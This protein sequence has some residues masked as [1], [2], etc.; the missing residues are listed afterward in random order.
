MTDD[1]GAT[2]VREAQKPDGAELAPGTLLGPYRIEARLGA[3]G[4]GVVYR[5]LDLRLN[6]PVAVKFLATRLLDDAARERFKREAR[7]ASALNHPNILTVHDVGEHAGRE[8]L[9]TELIEA[10]TLEEWLR[11]HD[12]RDWRGAVELLVGVA[13]GLAEA[14]A[15]GILHRDIKPSN[16]LVSRGGHAKLADFGLAKLADDEARPGVTRHTQPGVAIGTVSYM[17]PEQATGHTLDVFSFGMLLYEVLAGHAAFPGRTDLEVMR[18]ILD[19]A[20]QPLSDDIPEPL[21]AAVE[22]ML[23]KNPAE[24]YQSMREVAVDL[25]RALR[26]TSSGAA[27]ASPSG[28]QRGPR[29]LPWSIGAAGVVFVVAFSAWY[30][31]TRMHE[32]TVPRV[33]VLPFVDLNREANNQLLVDG[34]HEEILTALT[35]RAG[36]AVQ[37]IPRTTMALYRGGA[38][39]ASVV[40]TELHATHVL[41]STVRRDGEEVRL[42]LRLIDARMDRSIWDK[43]YTRSTQVSALQLQS[44]VAGDVAAQLSAKLSDRPRAT[45][46][47]SSDPEAAEAFVRATLMQGRLYGASPVEAWRDVESSYTRAIERDPGFV[48][49]LVARGTL[50]QTLFEDG[51]DSSDRQLGLARADLAEAQRLAPGDPL[52][53]AA[54]AEMAH[55]EGESLRAARLLAAAES[56]GLAGVPLALLQSRLGASHESLARFADLDPGNVELSLIDW[57]NYVSARGPLEALRALDDA[58][59]RAERIGASTLLWDALRANTIFSFTGNLEPL[60]PLTDPAQVLNPPAGWDPEDGLRVTFERFVLRGEYRNARDLIDAFHRDSVRVVALGGVRSP[61]IGRHPTADFRGWADML[62][63][64][65]DAARADGRTL[66]AAVES[67]PET[68]WNASFLAALKADA[69]LFTGRPDEAAATATALVE[70]TKGSQIHRGAE[71]LAARVLAWAGRGDAAVDLLTRLATDRPGALPADIARQPLY[72]TPLRDNARF[73]ALK[74]RL[75]AEMRATKLE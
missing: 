53:L 64:D 15:A 16:V 8:Y 67:T 36:D 42:T 32:Q 55:L 71:T 66:L 61:G 48:R 38:K 69:Q 43:A 22:K 57:G 50:R 30:A 56:A 29:W 12:R 10:G 52:V 63:G 54:A 6:R 33:A 27:V 60:A 44:E 17:S 58:K 1:R 37:V 19:T 34:L 49:A 4:M 9:V 20:P 5:A 25:R 18:A 45:A 59:A 26:K 13:D 40:A 39:P 68:R 23:E 14:H 2:D 21:R 7:L 72:T 28:T 11:K 31:S 73:A 35:D 47:L 3:G 70:S 74:E 65:R 41:E 62:L 24:R 75:E 46:K 51:Y